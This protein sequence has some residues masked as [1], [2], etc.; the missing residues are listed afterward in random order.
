MIKK[1]GLVLALTFAP[2]AAFAQTPAPAAA[3]AAPAEEH[4]GLSTNS[5]VGELFADPAA[6]EVLERHVP[7]LVG[8][9]QLQQASGMQFSALAAYVP[10][11]TPEKLAE[12]DRD[13]AAAAGH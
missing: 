9:P 13:L 5:T 3:A 2:V 7:E 1:I 8:N 12:I 4:A 11:L 10:T 6:H